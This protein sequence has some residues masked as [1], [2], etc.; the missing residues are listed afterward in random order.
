MD[1]LTTAKVPR[2][3]MTK[4]YADVFRQ[5]TQDWIDNDYPTGQYAMGYFIYGYNLMLYARKSPKG[6]LH[7]SVSV[8]AREYYPQV[9][10]TTHHQPRWTWNQFTRWS[11]N[12]LRRAMW[13]LEQRAIAAPL[14]Q[15]IIYRLDKAWSLDHDTTM[16]ILERL[17]DFGYDP[18]PKQMINPTLYKLSLRQLQGIV[19]I[20]NGYIEQGLYTK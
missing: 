16:E 14:L 20:I 10:H 13:L 9:Q 12:L 6:G 3:Q 1:K 5:R 11:E 2:T 15:H 17:E 18:G 4:Y 19:M 8:P 7:L